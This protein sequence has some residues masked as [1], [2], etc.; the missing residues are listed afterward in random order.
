MDLSDGEVLNT[1]KEM[2]S[3]ADVKPFKINETYKSAWDQRA[4]Q[5]DDPDGDVAVVQP[6]QR[7]KGKAK[8]KAVKP[9]RAPAAVSKVKNDMKRP[10]SE[11]SY[12]P[13]VYKERRAKY[14]EDQKAK[15]CTHAMACTAWN[16]CPEKTNLLAGLSVS[17]LVRRRFLPKGSTKNPWVS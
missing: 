8:A 17:E 12:E 13:H 7:K 15:G 3:T 16:L 1:L 4:E 11:V 5:G 2:N 10:A 9:T 14:I 6:K